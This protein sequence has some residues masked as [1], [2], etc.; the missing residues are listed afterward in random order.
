MDN[1]KTE[2]GR[3]KKKISRPLTIFICIFMAFVLLFGGTVLT[4]TLVRQSRYAAEYKGFGI[5]TKTATYLTSYYKYSYI[6]SLRRAGVNA[7]DT[8]SFWA[9]KPEGGTKTY[10]ELLREGAEDYIKKTIVAVYLYNS[11]GKLSDKDEDKISAAISYKLQNG[12]D[13]DGT[14]KTFNRNTEQ[15]G[16]NYK[17]FKKAAEI[18]YKASRARSPVSGLLLE[19]YPDGYNDYLQTY[20]HVKLIFVDG[21]KKIG[22]DGEPTDL[23]A[24]EKA[25]LATDLAAFRSNIANSL[26]G[27]EAFDAFAEKYN[28]VASIIGGTEYY[29]APDENFTKTTM[30]EA[31]PEVVKAALSLPLEGREAAIECDYDGDPDNATTCF[32][33]KYKPQSYDYGK[34]QYEAYF[35]D[36]E[37][38]AMTYLYGKILTLY[39]ADAKLTDKFKSIDPLSLKYDYSYFITQF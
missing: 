13:M 23:T 35:T 31:F 12:A 32:I 37:A 6:T 27:E 1:V 25:S 19:E 20:S 34:S 26:A 5:D 14:V 3:T 4:V 7:L 18:L 38:N 36:F 39:A 2:T 33:Y 16:Y 30:A 10:G 17:S 22:A 21:A 9:S 24:E 28:C 11:Y 29:L 8:E 15:Y